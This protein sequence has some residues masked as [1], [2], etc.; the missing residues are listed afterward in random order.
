MKKKRY[1]SEGTKDDRK[2]NNRVKMTVKRAKD[3]SIGIQCE[4]IEIFLN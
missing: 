2:T 4:E 3:D 1:K